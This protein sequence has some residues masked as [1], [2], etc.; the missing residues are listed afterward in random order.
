MMDA[1]FNPLDGSPHKHVPDWCPFL[2]GGG[3]EDWREG[4]SSGASLLETWRAQML[5]LPFSGRRGG[6]RAGRRGRDAGLH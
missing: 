2:G 5:V 3:E 1:R 4:K 6:M